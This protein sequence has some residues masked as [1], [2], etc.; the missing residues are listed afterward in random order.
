MKDWM[1]M[2]RPSTAI[3]R[4]GTS[5]TKGSNNS[6]VGEEKAE[7][8]VFFSTKIRFLNR[9]GLMGYGNGYGISLSNCGYEWYNLATNYGVTMS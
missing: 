7:R 2:T 6:T 3:I 1:A 4:H 8:D 5:G 9:L